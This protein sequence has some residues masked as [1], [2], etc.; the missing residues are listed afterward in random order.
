[1][2]VLVPPMSKVMRL[3]SPRERRD[4]R[5]AL[6]GDA[7]RRAREHRARGEADRV[8][9]GGDAAVRLHD[10]H[11]ARDSPPRA[12]APPRRPQV[13]G[14][15]RAHVGV[16]HG[17]A[18]ALVLLDLRQ[19]LGGERHVGVGQQAGEEP[20]R[21]PLVPRDRGRSGGS[22]PRPRCTPSGRRRPRPPRPAERP[23]ES[24]VSTLPSKRIRS[25]HVEPARA[26]H[27]RHRRRHAQVVAVV[28]QALAHL[29]RRRGGP[30]W[31]ACPTVAPFRSSR[32][33]VATVVPCT[34]QLG[35]A[36][37]RARVGAELGGE[38][39]EAVH[40][41]DGRIG[42]GGGGLGEAHAAGVVD[43]DQV[44]EGPADV[45]SDA[46]Q[47]HARGFRLID[48][49]PERHFAGRRSAFDAV[50]RSPAD[51]A[52]A[53]R[54]AAAARGAVAVAAAAHGLDEEDG[55]GQDRAR[56][57]PSSSA[58]A[59]CPLR[60]HPVA[61]GK[62][63]LAAEDPVGRMA[64]AVARGVAERGR[65]SSPCAARAREPTPPR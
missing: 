22:R 57:P 40:H 48:T 23:V 14:E 32:A 24:G 29:D 26:R 52:V 55:A 36:Q 4:A 43:C 64:H 38:E 30:R 65:A 19:H 60:D 8:G 10:Q 13:A 18:E 44:G 33:L 9:D 11:V 31:S 2:S 16:H 21:L 28:L 20:A 62:A 59:S 3:P 41:A 56:R 49:A 15:H 35:V 51:E 12:A 50:R 17:R 45:D 34:M 39:P 25:R 6:P 27:Q 5:G 37:Q 46:Q 54:L 47:S 1:M 58:R 61:V 53:C 63:V 7:A 42:G